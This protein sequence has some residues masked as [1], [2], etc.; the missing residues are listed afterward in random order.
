[1]G[2]DG[3]KKFRVLDAARGWHSNIFCTPIFLLGQDESQGSITEKLTVNSQTYFCLD[4][5]QPRIL[6]KPQSELFVVHRIRI[7]KIH[8]RIISVLHIM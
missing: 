4:K 3:T 6:V 5:G 7:L 1:M 2:R 8:K